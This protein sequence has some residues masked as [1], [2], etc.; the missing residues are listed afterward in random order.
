MIQAAVWRI[1]MLELKEF[2]ITCG[3][4]RDTFCP[5]VI[6]SPSCTSACCAWRGLLSEKYA[7]RSASLSLRPN[8][9]LYQNRKG[10][11]TSATAKSE[12]RRYARRPGREDM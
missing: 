6:R 11:R 1:S 12:M 5:W 9:V 3:Y 2:A 7:S 4:Q 10:S 8:Q